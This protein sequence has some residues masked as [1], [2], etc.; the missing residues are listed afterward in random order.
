[1]ANECLDL[2]R[3]IASLRAQQSKLTSSASPQQR[4]VL[5]DAIAALDARRKALG[6][7]AQPPHAPSTPANPTPTIAAKCAELRQRVAQLTAELRRA[8][9]TNA[10]ERHLA[11][12]AEIQQLT[13]QEAELGCFQT[14]KPTRT[15]A[16]VWSATIDYWTD[17]DAFNLKHSSATASISVT[18][19]EWWYGWAVRLGDFKVTFGHKFPIYVSSH[20]G[21]GNYVAP[22]TLDLHVPLHLDATIDANTGAKIGGDIAP[23]M[24][25]NASRMINGMTIVGSAIDAAGNVAVVGEQHVDEASANFVFKVSGPLSARP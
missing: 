12:A 25:T 22:G 21:E 8:P 23:D 18:F 7:L 17:G 4:R 19:L 10:P 16:A 1:M 3:Q 24:S 11:I 2:A 13:D 9:I 20:L 15:V 14:L 6:C 5:A